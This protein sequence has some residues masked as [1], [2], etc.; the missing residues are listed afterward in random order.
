MSL[1]LAVVRY[2]GTPQNGTGS[3]VA[4]WLWRA[5]GNEGDE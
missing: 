1:T 4:T 2:L 5:S 3:I